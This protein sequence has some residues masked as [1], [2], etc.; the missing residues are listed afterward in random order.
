MNDINKYVQEELIK[1]Y[2]SVFYIALFGCGGVIYRKH[3]LALLGRKN[4]TILKRLEENSLIKQRKIGQSSIIILK[5]AVFRYFGLEGKAVRLS[6]N[7][8]LHSALF[9]EMLLETYSAED[10]RKMEQMLKRSNFA[11]YTPRNNY[12]ILN[13]IYSFL[14][15]RSEGDL[16]AL[17]WA[18]EQ[19]AKKIRF[20]E[21]SHIGRREQ[22]PKASVETDDLMTL[23]QNGIY[24]RDV[25]YIDGI[26]HLY[27]A[28]FITNKTA[29]QI[30][31]AITRTET[32]IAD[33]FGDTKLYC[34]FDMYSLGEKAERKENRVLYTLLHR[35][36]NEWKEAYYTDCLTYHWH[37]CKKSLL[38]GIDMYRWL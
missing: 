30:V 3:L 11:C 17:R 10:I 1:R 6:A 21:E 5:H 23:Q 33:I 4:A 15:K 20:M 32:A 26:L 8:L 29:E 34:H 9:G 31:S 2:Q 12:Y 16:D 25:D 35:N 28:L 38:S 19:M 24:I 7:K 37:N 27:M 13:R 36:G 18:V 22:L 14:E